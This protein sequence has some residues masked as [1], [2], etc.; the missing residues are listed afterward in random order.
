LLLAKFAAA[1]RI[2]PMMR[3]VMEDD[4]VEQRIDALSK[5]AEHS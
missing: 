5:G 3:H 1:C 2:V 4:D